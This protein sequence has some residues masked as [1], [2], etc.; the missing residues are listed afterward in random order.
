MLFFHK[1]DQDWSMLG[2]VVCKLLGLVVCTLL[3]LVVCTLLGL[4]VCTMLG[5]VD[6]PQWRS[7]G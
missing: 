1:L 6:E 4:V 3:G 7:H 5:L 2:L